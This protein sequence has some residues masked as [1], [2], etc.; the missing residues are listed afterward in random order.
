MLPAALYAL[1]AAAAAVGIG[2]AAAASLRI[3]PNTGERGLLGLLTI[4]VLSALI[5]FFLPLSPAVHYAILAAGFVCAALYWRAVPR[6]SV[7]LAALAFAAI[8]LQ[9][10]PRPYHDNGLYHIP[11]YLWNTTSPLV[12]GLANLHDR[13]GFNSLLFLIAP[14]VAPVTLG[15]VADALVAA[16][17]LLAALERLP[18]HAA[19]AS[20]IGFWFLASLL[21]LGVFFTGLTQWVG[22]FN[23]DGLAGALIVYWSFLL[24]EYEHKIRPETVPALLILIA[25]FA[26]MVKLAAAP[27][28]LA[29]LLFL[30]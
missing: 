7:A 28:L 14:V 11:T 19:K 16:F 30:G 20:A 29:T 4:G 1:L 22:V 2:S 12:V 10:P 17:V 21:I 8:L 26:V 3:N 23:A 6:D 5:H 9:P 25:A 13:L 18:R 24:L 27:L 15:W